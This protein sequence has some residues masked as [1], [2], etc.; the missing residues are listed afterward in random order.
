M[1]LLDLYKSR[2]GATV[3]RQGGAWNGPC[4]LCG[5]E[6]GK[7]DRFMVWPD[8]AESLGETCASHNITGI[9][10]CRQCGASG[11]TIAYLMKIDGLDFKA[12]LAEL[13]I[14]G[15]RAEYRRRRAP[16][17]PRRTAA[18]VWT[19][20]EWPEPSEQWSTYAAKLLAEAEACIEKQPAALNWLAARGITE[21]AVRA[22]RIGYLPAESARYPGRYRARSALGLTPRI[23]DDGRKRSKI[24]IPRGIVI[25]TFAPDGHIIN[26]R[27]RRHKG[28][29]SER[30][31][32][33]LELEG[34]CKAPLLLRSSRP[35]PLAAYFVTEAE[36]DAML[37]HAATGGVVGALAVRTNRGKPDAVAHALLRDAVRVCIALDYDEPGADGV[38]FWERTYPTSL[39]WPTPEGK[40]PGDAYRLGVDIREW[41]AAA[42]PSSI[43]LPM[44][45][46]RCADDGQAGTL[47]SGPL[48][49]GGGAEPETASPEKGSGPAVL[50]PQMRTR[51]EIGA[52]PSAWAW[53]TE[54]AFTPDELCRL[55][56]ALPSY[57][58]LDLVP[59]DVAL[60]YL[61]W[62]GI[63][64][65]FTKFRDDNGD[66][67]GF[68]W[69]RDYTW[70]RKNP[71]RFEA[72]WRFQQHSPVLW[73]WMSD[74]P[75]LKITSQNLLHIWGK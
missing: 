51:E 68:L 31:P 30:S 50:A 42:L 46:A 66:S 40:D 17:E 3:K 28:D 37:I 49:V 22:Y 58:P 25:P 23:G 27:I 56:A 7:S 61:L 69:D 48:D 29:L 63:P 12:A 36:L 67:T 38:D 75:E 64:A 2:F 59:E 11:D 70:C 1:Q 19:P 13:G 14:E 53:A 60:A 21:E 71:E 54:D 5:G 73:Q 57:L 4:P 16:A 43:S 39:R 72:F 45:D 33:Y 55:Q 20:R 74:H 32:K 47:P 8:R 41:A 34:S 65:T 10:S 26:L 24:F 44:E 15:G 6:P 52:T 18:Q 62:R 35:G 9:W